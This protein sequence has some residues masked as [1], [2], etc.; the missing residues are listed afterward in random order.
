VPP[1]SKYW[2][3][4]HGSNAWA[5]HSGN[6]DA[7]R[8]GAL[9][10]VMPITCE[11]SPVLS[12]NADCIECP[13]RRSRHHRALEVIEARRFA[14]PETYSAASEAIVTSVL[15]RCAAGGIRGVLW[16]GGGEPTLLPFLP[17]MCA[18]AGS[19]GMVNAL[20]TNGFLIGT[21]AG[22]AESLLEPSVNI[23][24]IRVS[25][26]AVSPGIVRKH[27]GV[28]DHTD[29]LTQ[30]DGLEHL[31][32]VRQ[33]LALKYSDLG[34]RLPSIQISTI[35]D[36]RNVTD[37]LPICDVVAQVF[38]GNPDARGDEDVIVV[39]PLTLHG[40]GQFSCNDHE[41]RVID[42]IIE[43][44]GHGSAGRAALEA[45][46][47]KPY[48]GFGVDLV[49]SGEYTSYSRLV[50]EQYQGRDRCWAHGLFLT[51]G[52]DGLVYPC[53]EMNCDSRFVI[54][55][56]KVQSVADVYA[57][58]ERSN[59]LRL[60]DGC[61]WGPSIFQPFSRTARLDRIASAI[62]SGE[63]QDP[64]IEAIRIASFSQ[65]PLLLN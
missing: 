16:T 45:A 27:W 49:E 24:F 59:F 53:T 50:Q 12:C 65:H 19:L 15:N 61:G 4:R 58:A 25:I 20:Y 31:L 18:Y 43:A 55:D 22:L 14:V 52:P 13:Y 41:Q 42:Q 47:V 64:T 17:K 37:L 39:R 32:K 34:L 29:V 6:I 28:K 21:E 36:S 3:V 1:S 5:Q 62:R 40:R 48:L 35:V 33:K 38:S 11:F 56:L 10:E 54:G 46:G 63:L 2:S 57:S 44:C 7:W 51:V 26:N 30:L 8:R 60:A 9:Q 23:V